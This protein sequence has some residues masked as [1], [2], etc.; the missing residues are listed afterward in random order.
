MVVDKQLTSVFCPLFLS[1]LFLRL[2]TEGSPRPR[3]RRRPAV[4]FVRRQLHRLPTAPVEVSQCHRC[5]YHLNSCI[6]K[7]LITA[8]DVCFDWRRFF[9]TRRPRAFSRSRCAELCPFWVSFCFLLGIFVLLVHLGTG[10]RCAP[11]FKRHATKKCAQIKG[12]KLPDAGQTA[13]NAPYL[14]TLFRSI[15]QR[16][17]EIS[18][19]DSMTAL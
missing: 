1:T 3:D 12:E 9:L 17:L 6:F 10:A 18:N 14:I 16:W 7:R 2:A 13:I 15:W 5:F 8:G 11:S 4:S 19:H